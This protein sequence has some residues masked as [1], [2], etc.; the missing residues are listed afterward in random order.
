MYHQPITPESVRRD[1]IRKGKKNTTKN[2]ANHQPMT[3][4]PSSITR[5]RPW[6]ERQRGE[7]SDESLYGRA[8]DTSGAR[9]ATETVQGTALA[10]ESIDNIERVDGLPLAVFGISD[11]VTN[12]GLEEGLEDGTSF[13]VDHWEIISHCRPPRQREK[14]VL[15]EIRLTP[16]RRARRRIAGL[17]MPW[18]LS[19]KILRWRLAP[20]LPRPFPPLPPVITMSVTVVDDG[21][22][23][24]TCRVGWSW[25]IM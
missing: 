15:A 21:P 13:L 25:A 5:S 12:D 18:M 10:L 11:R 22:H 17:V 6:I 9:S 2:K 1:K 16:P 19:R 7:I 23:Q 4:S 3:V 14:H 8:S 20:P 24:R